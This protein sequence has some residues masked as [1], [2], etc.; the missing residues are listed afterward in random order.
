[1]NRVYHVLRT[2]PTIAHLPYAAAVLWCVLVGVA[3]LFAR[4][5]AV[6]CA[7]ATY[8]L[9]RLLCTRD[10][11]FFAVLQ[12]RIKCLRFWRRGGEGSWLR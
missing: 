8:A 4:F 1:M 9:A 7:V 10:P 3:F 6:P 2:T 11:Q 12:A 5:W